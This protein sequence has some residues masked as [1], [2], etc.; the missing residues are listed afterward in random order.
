ME[1]LET[2]QQNTESRTMLV[3]DKVQ[4]IQGDYL[5]AHK[6]IK[7][8]KWVDSVRFAAG[9]SGLQITVGH[10]MADQNLPMSDKIATLVG[11]FVQPFFVATFDYVIY[12]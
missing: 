8:V 12:K 7:S 6:M 5:F 10:A 2:I 11:H 9:M 4:H 1:R 3:E